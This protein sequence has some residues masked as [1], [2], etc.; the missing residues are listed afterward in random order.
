[1]K[2]LIISNGDIKDY[3]FY[4]KLLKDVDMVICADGGANHA[5]QMKIKPDLIIGDFDSIK[6]EILEFYE[7]E[8]VRIEKFP[9][10]KDETDTQLAMLKAIELGA[11]EITFI[12]VIGERLDHSYANLSLLLYLLNRNI[13]GKIVNEMNEIYLIN[14]FIEVEGKKGELLSLLPYSKEVKG[15]YTKGLFYGLS[16]QSMDLEMPYGISNVFTEDKATIEIEEGL[17][18]VIKPRE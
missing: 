14:K 9:P 3:N 13:K 7:N 1:M 2:V 17:L 5:Y 4:E 15:I 10:M 18:L 11:K 8:G 12:G 16:G 6:E